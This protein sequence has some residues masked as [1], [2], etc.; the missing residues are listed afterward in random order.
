VEPGNVWGPV[1]PEDQVTPD[2]AYGRYENNRYLD[3]DPG[4]ADYANGDIQLSRGAAARLGVEWIDLSKIG[5]TA[6]DLG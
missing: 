1:P 5:A 6:R 3:Y 2:P 4:F